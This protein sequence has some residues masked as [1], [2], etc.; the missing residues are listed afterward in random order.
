MVSHM[1]FEGVILVLI[2]LSSIKLVVDTY[3]FDL[4]EDDPIVVTSAQIDYFFTAVF[5]LES[6]LK[7]LAYGFI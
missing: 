4:P 3:L 5:A 2:I 6:F 1:G 7:S